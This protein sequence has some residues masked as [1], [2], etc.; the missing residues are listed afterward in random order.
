TAMKKQGNNRSFLTGLI[1]FALILLISLDPIWTYANN[2][3]KSE[4][5]DMDVYDE[6]RSHWFNKLT[7]NEQYDANNEDMARYMTKLDERISNDEETG[8]W[9]TMNLSEDRDYLWESLAST[10]DSSHI[11]NLYNRL[12]DMALTYTMVGSDFYENEDLKNDIIDAL[13]WM[14]DN[15]YNPNKN[16]YGNW[17]DWEIGT[18]QALNDV[19]VL[20]YDEL[21]SDALRNYV[22]TVDHFVPDPNYRLNGVEETGANLLDKVLV[23][24]LSGVIDKDSYKITLGSDSMGKEYLYVDQGDGV[25][26]DGS[27][28]QHFNLAYTGG[29]GAVWLSRT[30][31]MLYLLKDSPWEITDPD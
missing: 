20:M 8:F 9:D 24:S 14:Y 7:G 21:P 27:L 30:A 31:D 5:A 22:E 28:V 13:E 4:G 2:E 3:E 11:L 6:V 17:W 12:K 15:R 23:V 10:T 29:Y 18:P 25:Y 1:L 16:E 19:L 26:E